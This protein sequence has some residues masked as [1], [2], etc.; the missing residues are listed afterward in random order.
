M[1]RLWGRIFKDNRMIKDCVA[2]DADY[3]KDR[4]TMVFDT[5][6]EICHK[7]DVAQ[8]LW[9]MPNIDDFVGRGKVRFTADNFIERI[10]FD[11]LEIQII[12]E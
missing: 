10:D 2:S 7:F 1:F 11:Y 5:L 6:G 8:P 4:K 3:S 12:E 9:L